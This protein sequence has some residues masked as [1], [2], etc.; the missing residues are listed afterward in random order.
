MLQEAT[1]YQRIFANHISDKKKV[2]IGIYKE[3]STLNRKK[4]KMLPDLSNISLK[5]IYKSY[6]GH[7][8]LKP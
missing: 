5:K 2:V 7:K 4:T 8:K 1:D 3:L 6:K